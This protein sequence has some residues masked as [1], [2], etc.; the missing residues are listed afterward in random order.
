LGAVVGDL[1]AVEKGWVDLSETEDSLEVSV[2]RR[3]KME[4]RSVS[5]RREKARRGKDEPE[6]RR[7]RVEVVELVLVVLASVERLTILEVVV[8]RR[9]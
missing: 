4:G 9:S 5:W 7:G 8:L 2:N 6:S 1:E 3:R